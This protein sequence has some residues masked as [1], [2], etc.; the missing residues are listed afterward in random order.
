MAIITNYKLMDAACCAVH[1]AGLRALVYTVNDAG[2]ARQLIALGIDGIVTD[3]VDRFLTGAVAADFGSSR[4]AFARECN[5][6]RTV[7][8][9]ASNNAT[10]AVESRPDCA[11]R[12]P[13]KGDERA[14]LRE[15]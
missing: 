6:Q 4:G 14:R 3:A 10:V 8:A 2:R 5:R 7:I 11:C 12:C 15:E 1:A 13:C 9:S